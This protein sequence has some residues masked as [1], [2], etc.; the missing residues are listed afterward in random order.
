MSSV[1]RETTE[2]ALQRLRQHFVENLSG[3]T[4][5]LEGLA[6]RVEPGP[7]TGAALTELR[8][9]LHRL[10]GTAGTFGFAAAAALVEEMEAEVE[11]WHAAGAKQVA[12]QRRARVLQFI[13]DFS[14][15]C[16]AK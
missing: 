15:A 10:R 5:A 6:D 9:Q 3:T 7:D 13:R 16:G 4:A 8:K 2:A 11:I 1:R 14:S 12:G